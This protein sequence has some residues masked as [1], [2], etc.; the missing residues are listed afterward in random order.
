MDIVRVDLAGR[1]YDIMIGPGLL[2]QAGAHIGP[3]LAGSERLDVV[4]E[5]GFITKGDRVRVI[6]SEGYRHVVTRV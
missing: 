6:R 1:G 4:S 3:L 5:G 2:G